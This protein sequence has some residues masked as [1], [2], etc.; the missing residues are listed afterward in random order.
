MDPVDFL[1]DQ[2][3]H[4]RTLFEEFMGTEDLDARQRV[5]DQIVD[6]LWVHHQVEEHV[7][8]PA[9][10]DRQPDMKDEIDEDL[11]EHRALERQL[12]QMQAGAAGDERYEALV[13]VTEEITTHHFDEEEEDLFPAVRD[14]FSDD[15][16]DELGDRMDVLSRQLRKTRDELVEEARAAGVE[17]YSDMNKQQLAEAITAS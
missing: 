1:E 17:G 4:T 12:E 9:M 15:E 14:A 6:L 3:R 13:E 7:L 2:H 16:L 5:A 11:E 8:Y 10:L